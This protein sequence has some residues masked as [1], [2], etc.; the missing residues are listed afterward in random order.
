MGKLQTRLIIAI[1]VTLYIV[2]VET[3][4]GVVDRVRRFSN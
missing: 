2:S 1:A 3:E 4:A